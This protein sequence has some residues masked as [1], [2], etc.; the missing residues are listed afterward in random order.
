MTI[1]PFAETGLLP[2]GTYP[3]TFDQLR[4]SHL[5][6]GLGNGDW[7]SAWRSRLLE[8][9]EILIGQLW[10]IG[11]TE[12]FLDGSFA[13]AKPH[14]N[15]IDGYFECEAREFARGYVATKLNALDP[16]KVWTWDPAARRPAPGSM[17]RQLPMWHRYR[18][19]LYPHFPGLMS[20]L[21]D[22]FGNQLQFPSAFRQQRGTG[23]RKG[24]VKI[25]P[26]LHRPSQ[27]ENP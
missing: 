1:P 27:G 10:D 26:T 25:V 6:T 7:D 12:V 19:E 15:D 9:A 21:V 20:G 8:N 14:P 17:K 2:L 18:V 13:E 23:V 4:E 5:V 24:I 3:V 22:P 16:N 11:I